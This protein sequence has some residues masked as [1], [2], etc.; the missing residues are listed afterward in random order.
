[1]LRRLVMGILAGVAVSATVVAAG[2][3]GKSWSVP[4]MPDG[5]PDIQGVWANNNMT[6]LE[7]P[8]HFGLR[9]TMTDAEFA[10][11][12]KSQHEDGGDAFF[13]DELFLAAVEGRTKFSSATPRP[14]TTVR[15]G[16][17]IASGQP[18]LADHR[19]AD[20]RIPALA[21]GAAERARAKPRPRQ[22]WARRSR[23]GSPRSARAASATGRRTSGPAIRATSK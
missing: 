18:H 11:K 20:G 9:A 19:S 17:P 10:A 13:A 22:T 21:P 14:A 2:Q 6:P 7:R 8:K 1:M 16:C 4:R 23:P 15:R 12:K 3:S 5:H